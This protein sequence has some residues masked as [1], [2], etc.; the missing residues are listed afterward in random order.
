MFGFN[1]GVVG[2]FSS[3]GIDWSA[4]NG[5]L[6][7]S[8]TSTT[9]TNN[10]SKIAIVKMNTDVL[11]AVWK[12]GTIVKAQVI[13]LSG[14]T[15]SFGSVTTVIDVSDSSSFTLSICKLDTGRAL[16]AYGNSTASIQGKV[17]SISGT[18]ITPGTQAELASDGGSACINGYLVPLDTDK[19]LMV[20]ARANIGK[21]VIITTSTTTISAVGSEYTF[22]AASMGGVIS[23]AVL[24][25]TTAIVA[26]QVS[27]TTAKAIVLS[28]SGTTIT[29]GTKATLDT[30]AGNNISI[31]ALTSTLAVA[32]YQKSDGTTGRSTPMTISGTTITAGTTAT[33]I[34]STVSVSGSGEGIIP[35]NATECMVLY[36]LASNGDPYGVV[37]ETNGST[38]TFGTP[39]SLAT[40]NS[41][42]T[43]FGGCSVDSGR[44]I[45]I[46]NDG[47]TPYVKVLKQT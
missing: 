21:S 11:L 47:N 43:K 5:S 39:V 4:W 37:G 22:E 25:T 17:L 23:A 12:E 18:T 24:T 41:A 29:G 28:V 36:T 3:G 6:D 7:G 14:T 13:T 46:Y 20:F 16:I 2:S 45:A 26:Y 30:D 15:P 35:L 10:G 32:T 19:T 31:C 27:T 8:S 40:V 1:F 38:I 34:A 9:G 42:G 33:Y 44:A